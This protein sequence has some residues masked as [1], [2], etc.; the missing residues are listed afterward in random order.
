MDLM[1]EVF[2]EESISTDRMKEITG[3]LI[4]NEKQY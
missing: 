2:G 3:D 4:M 1:T